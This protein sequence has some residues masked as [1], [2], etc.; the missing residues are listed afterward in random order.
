MSILAEIFA[1]KEHEVASRKRVKPLAEVRAE[2]ESAP[3]PPDFV[4]ALQSA[5][6]THASPALIAEIKKASPSRG[7][8]AP[9]FD[10]L[11]LAQLYCQNGAA[12]I[13]V[14]TDERYFQGRLEYL[15]QV[16]ACLPAAPLLRK[17]FILDPY[18]LYEA[19]AAGASAALLIVAGLDASRLRDLH[20][21]AL[22]LGLAPLVEVHTL[23]ELETALSCK[24]ILVGVNNRDLRDFSVSLQTT[25][26][27]RPFIPAGICLVAESGIHTRQDVETLKDAGTDAILVGE[28]LVTARDIGEKARELS[29]CAVRQSG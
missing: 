19:R 7:M 25:G 13:S 6:Q 18:Q 4:A 28:A 23:A 2:A 17:D 12:A 20:N 3:T 21:L 27:L 9:N 10:P 14:L 11:H 8:L 15:A 29:Q 26:D 5:R 1:H 22:E 16:H 24:P